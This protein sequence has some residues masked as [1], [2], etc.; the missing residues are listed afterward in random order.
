MSCTG[1]IRDH[2]H[3]FDSVSFDSRSHNP[4]VIAA[5]L[6]LL[7]FY[8]IPCNAQGNPLLHLGLVTKS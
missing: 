7:Y 6:L 2:V 8:C 1:H 3:P 4:S 5:D